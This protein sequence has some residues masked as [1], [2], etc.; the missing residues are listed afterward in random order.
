MG[1][2]QCPDCDKQVSDQA[3]AC[4]HCGRPFATNR[5]QLVT[6]LNDNATAIGVIGVIGS[7][8]VMIVS[9]PLGIFL[10]LCFCGFLLG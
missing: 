3:T 4:I 2:V 5:G 9:L 6:W 8:L 7:L 1:L 10:L